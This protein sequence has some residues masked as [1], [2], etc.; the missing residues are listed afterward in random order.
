MPWRIEKPGGF[1]VTAGLTGQSGEA[2]E[3]VGSAQ[4]CLH[5]GG[6]RKSVVGVALGLLRLTLRDRDASARGQRPH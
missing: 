6:D 5:A 1:A 3:D 2:L 4:I